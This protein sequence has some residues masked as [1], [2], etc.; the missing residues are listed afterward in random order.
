MSCHGEYLDCFGQTPH[1]RP[2]FVQIKGLLHLLNA[3]PEHMSP[4]IL[5]NGTETGPGAHG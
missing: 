3:S 2:L 1:G 5:E 4:G